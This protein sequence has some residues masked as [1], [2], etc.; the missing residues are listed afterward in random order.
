MD[1]GP[2][3]QGRIIDLY[4]WSCHDALRFGR[5]TIQLTVLRLGWNPQHSDTSGRVDDL[6]REREFQRSLIPIPSRRV[7]PTGIITD[8]ATPT[9]L[10]AGSDSVPGLP[11][12]VAPIPPT[13]VP[14]PP[15]P[16]Q[17]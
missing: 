6:F 7:D 3:V 11:P 2:A 10:P 12:G 9:S 1:T 15:P 13:P 14:P 16:I 17:V 5:R 4:L 8:P